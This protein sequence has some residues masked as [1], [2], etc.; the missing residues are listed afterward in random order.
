MIGHS[1]Q[2]IY[3][4]WLKFNQ[5]DSVITKHRLSFFLNWILRLQLSNQI[6]ESSFFDTQYF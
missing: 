4:F 1:F 2:N 6:E 5:V 3:G